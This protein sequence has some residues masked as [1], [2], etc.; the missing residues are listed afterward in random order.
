MVSRYAIP[1]RCTILASRVLFVALSLLDLAIVLPK[2]SLL[3]NL[4]LDLLEFPFSSMVLEALTLTEMLLALSGTLTERD[5]VVDSTSADAVWVYD[6]AG[7]YTA[8]LTASDGNGG[9]TTT[10]VEISVG[11]KPVPVIVSPAD[12]DTFA[13]GD[14][15]TLIGSATAAESSSNLPNT[16]LT[17]EVQQHHD[18]HYHPFLDLT[19]G[20]NIV[21][22][23]AP[24]PKITMRQATVTLRSF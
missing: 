17:R 11:N 9:S 14:I 19:V 18:A 21:L 6:T 7:L 16:S 10:K 1:R 13:V 22:S 24:E 2:L 20:N 3:Q 4:L 8:T 12:G 15:I 5:G 23:P